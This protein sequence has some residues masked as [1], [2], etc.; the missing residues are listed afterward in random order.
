MAEAWKHRLSS[1]DRGYG[2][3]YRRC[4][5]Q[6][7]SQEPTCRHCRAKGRTT[8]ATVTDHIIPLAKGGAAHNIANLQPLCQECHQNKSNADKGHRVRRRIGLDG[9]PEE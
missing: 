4:R 6:L 8:L 3:D 2:R 1:K 5:A 9:W 7:L